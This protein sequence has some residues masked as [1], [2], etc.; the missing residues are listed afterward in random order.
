MMKYAD[1][2]KLQKVYG[3][4]HDLLD[5]IPDVEI[6]Q[7]GYEQ[8]IEREYRIDGWIDLNRGGINYA[9]IIE[10]K[11]NGAPRFV[12][13]AVYQLKSFIA[14]FIQSEHAN[15][16]Q[17]LI[18]MLVS[19]YLSPESRAICIKHNVAYLD[20]FGNAHLVFDGVYIDRAVADKPKFETRALRSIFSPRAGAVLRVM[21]SYPGHA[22][23]V[24]ELAEKANASFGHVSNVRKYL[25][26]REWIEKKDDGVVLVQPDALLKAWRENYRRPFG[27]RITGYT[28][29]HGEQLEKRL[30]GVL[31]SYSQRPRAI[32]SLHSAA[33]WFAPYGRDGTYNF[34]T[35]EPGVQTVT[36]ALRLMP[37]TRGANVVF[38][39]PMD[40]SLFDDAIEPAPGVFCT[41]PIVTY[42]DLWNGNDRDR[43]AADYIAREFFPWME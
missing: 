13:S 25:L 23:R 22:W 26:E 19:P 35:D 17:H 14:D 1:K 32:Y 43:E 37:A 11:E 5:H 18:P 24:A 2:M 6:G 12:R 16:S 33:Q 7:V 28:H 29:L 3:A 21:L 40:E 42:L 31:N 4:V 41:S 20:L 8:K 15:T 34:Y 10:M 36:E 9:L 27:R 30:L 38:R 39:I